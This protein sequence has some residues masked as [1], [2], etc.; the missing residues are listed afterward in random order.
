MDLISEPSLTANGAPVVYTPG[1]D[2]ESFVAYCEAACQ[3]D[4]KRVDIF[5]DLRNF[6][7]LDS[8]ATLAVLKMRSHF[9]ARGCGFHLINASPDLLAV[10]K[11]TRLDRIIDIAQ[12]TS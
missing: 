8:R 5:L 3:S 1:T 2:G 9:G 12:R 7:F 10:L 4:A 6:N 11:N